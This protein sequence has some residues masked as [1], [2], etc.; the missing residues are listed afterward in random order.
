MFNNIYFVGGIHGVGKSTIC[1]D[2]CR[3]LKINYLSA[4]DVLKWNTLNTDL[5]NKKVQNISQ[6]QDL[7]IEGLRAC[8][9]N[10][11]KYLL[12]GHYCLFN[13]EGE[14]TRIPFETFRTINPISLS[15]IINAPST[16]KS[17]LELR[18]NR[19]YDINLLSN[20]LDLEMEY[21]R[22]LS[23][24]LDVVLLVGEETNY[25]DM[26]KNMIN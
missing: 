21:A 12:D 18:D 26:I 11:E 8:V 24:K 23:Q 20:M 14:I 16:I 6:T 17:R 13:K 4:S 3:Q 10:D 25:I 15:I 1:K 19:K 2:I 22:E 5:K 9:K 7:L